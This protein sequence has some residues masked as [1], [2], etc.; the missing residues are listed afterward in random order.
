MQVFYILKDIKTHTKNEFYPKFSLKNSY[1]NTL[2]P[3][4][5]ILQKLS[6]SK[7]KNQNLKIISYWHIQPRKLIQPQAP[8]IF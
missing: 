4:S 1:S 3:I 5:N 6:I 2:N 8:S 7:I